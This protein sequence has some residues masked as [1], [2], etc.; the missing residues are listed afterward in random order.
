MK[1]NIRISIV[2]AGR[3]ANILGKAWSHAGVEIVEIYSRNSD[4][5]NKL[6][7]VLK[8]KVA[9][10]IGNMATN[11]DAVAVLVSDDAIEAVATRLP[12]E[13]ARFHSSGITDEAVMGGE[14]GVLWPIKSLNEE[15]AT[16]SLSGVPFGVNAN[17]DSLK[18]ILE[19]LVLAVDGSSFDAPKDVRSKVHLAA[20]FTD[21]FANHCLALSQQILEESGLPPDLMKPLAEGMARGAN[22]GTSYSRQTGVALR[23]D[24]GSQ[25]KH[26][27]LL[28]HFNDAESLTD[29][30]KYLSKHISDNHET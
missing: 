4:K 28:S 24:I 17:T 1:S 21:N 12:K 26:L 27:L 10:D 30:Y 22:K 6:A 2:G 19:N 20:V 13:V 8:A 18:T 23:R 14:N 25:E 11:I 7:E 29:F 9:T 15:S 16:D 3:V 5:A